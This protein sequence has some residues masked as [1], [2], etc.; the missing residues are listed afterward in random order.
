MKNVTIQPNDVNCPALM[1]SEDITI[2]DEDH[3]TCFPCFNI[4][5]TG[6]PKPIG[7]WFYYNI[8][9][10]CYDP[11]ITNESDPSSSY[12]VE[13]EGEVCVVFIYEKCF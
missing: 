1:S 8:T 7:T 5:V 10:Y 11:V 3:P 12:F 4:S 9:T 6:T 13:E 2:G